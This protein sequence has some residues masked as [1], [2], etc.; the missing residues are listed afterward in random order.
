MP[1]VPPDPARP[2]G[3]DPPRVFTLYPSSHPRMTPE[4]L[5]AWV[6]HAELRA[7]VE[8]TNRR[9]DSLARCLS[10][11]AATLAS[12]VEWVEKRPTPDVP[13]PCCGGMFP[14]GED[15]REHIANPP[16][17]WCDRER[18]GSLHEEEIPE[19]AERVVL[20]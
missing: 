16:N 20:S 7:L 17:E 4:Q 2:A 6:E 1:T 18:W 3:A 12:A 5:A 19:G 14:V 15:L 8:E 9:V 10:I 13:C 11:V